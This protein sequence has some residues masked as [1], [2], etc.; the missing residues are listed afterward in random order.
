MIKPMKYPRISE[1]KMQLIADRWNAGDN[2]TK[3]GLAI[4]KSA[5]SVAGYLKALIDQ[6]KYLTKHSHQN[7]VQERID[8]NL[9][10]IKNMRLRHCGAATIAKEIGIGV[11]ACT[12]ALRNMGL[13]EGYTKETSPGFRQDIDQ[14][15]KQLIAINDRFLEAL[16]EHCKRPPVPKYDGFPTFTR[17][18]ISPP[19]SYC[20]SPAD[21]C[22][23]N[24]S[25]GEQ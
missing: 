5:P 21:M 12:M 20:G 7:K 6:G 16:E 18:Y 22:E 14:D 3:I 11:K 8:K 17:I 10:L 23:A 19:A 25:P 24:N 13:F 2:L 4:G 9:E 1:E 15:K